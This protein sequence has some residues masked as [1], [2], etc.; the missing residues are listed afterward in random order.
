MELHPGPLT[1]SAG[2]TAISDAPMIGL[3]VLINVKLMFAESA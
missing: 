2:T 1:V 3:H